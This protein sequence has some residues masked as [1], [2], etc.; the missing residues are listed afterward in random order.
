MNTNYLEESYSFIYI[1]KIK[2]T[3]DLYFY[4]FVFAKTIFERA[5]ELCVI[6]FFLILSKSFFSTAFL[7]MNIKIVSKGNETKTCFNKYNVAMDP[8]FYV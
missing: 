2:L 1:L 7:S 6:L 8:W 4:N 5:G 3:W